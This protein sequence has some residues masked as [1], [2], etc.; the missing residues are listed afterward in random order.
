MRN[1]NDCSYPQEQICPR[2]CKDGCKKK[3]PRP[4]VSLD[5][6]DEAWRELEASIKR[7]EKEHA[8]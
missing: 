6:E 3:H 4:K 7:R 8:D 5:L 1:W 2:D